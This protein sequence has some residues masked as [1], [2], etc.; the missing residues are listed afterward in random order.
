[1]ED[2]LISIVFDDDQG[3]AILGALE[4]FKCVSSAFS[5][6][7]IEISIANRQRFVA[8]VLAIASKSRID[9]DVE[10]KVNELCEIA[11]VDHVDVKQEVERL[12]LA[13]VLGQYRTMLIEKRTLG[14]VVLEARTMFGGSL[15]GVLRQIVA[16]ATVIWNDDRNTLEA[17]IPT[18][19]KL[20]PCDEAFESA[21]LI[22]KA[23]ARK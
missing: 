3:L 13:A 6:G 16:L 7:G 20:E 21:L 1:V 22:E 17:A 5:K 12:K 11:G 18:L 23:I 8:R 15:K 4:L 14:D 10:A 2:G 9:S 19:L